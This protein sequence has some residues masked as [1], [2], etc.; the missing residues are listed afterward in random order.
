MKVITKGQATDRIAE[1]N[2]RVFTVDFIKRTTGEPRVMNARLGVKKH[3]KGGTLKYNPASK[4]LI[5]VFDM[6]KK[7][8]RMVDI[9]TIYGLR[10]DGND[11]AVK[12]A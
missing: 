3:L 7:G 12:G 11:Y 10:I 2:G 8:Y 6:Q 4:N 9:D 5:S 1:S